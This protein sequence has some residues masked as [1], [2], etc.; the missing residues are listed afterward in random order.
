[1]RKT[2]SVLLLTNTYSASIGRIVTHYYS[3]NKKKMQ[4]CVF[5]TQFNSKPTSLLYLSLWH[6]SASL[7]MLIST[8]FCRPLSG[9]RLFL[10]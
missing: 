10:R 7:G 6:N 3:K 9:R 8:I 1:M 4:S 5:F 2:A